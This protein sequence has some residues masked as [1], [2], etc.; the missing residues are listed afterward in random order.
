[1]PVI[2]VLQTLVSHYLCPGAQ[3]TGQ[4]KE[5]WACPHQVA[6]SSIKRMTGT[7]LVYTRPPSPTSARRQL[8]PSEEILFPHSGHSTSAMHIRIDTFHIGTVDSASTRQPFHLPPLA[9]TSTDPKH[10]KAARGATGK[11]SL[12]FTDPPDGVSYI[13]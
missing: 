6:L 3:A 12:V 10:V 1:M 4:A 9:S 13:G 7:S 2:R 5:V 11:V 8:T